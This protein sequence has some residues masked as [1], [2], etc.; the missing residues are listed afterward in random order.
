M[1]FFTARQNSRLTI[2]FAYKY[3]QNAS[4]GEIDFLLC[5]AMI[6]VKDGD[7]AARECHNV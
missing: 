4:A 5:L 3:P 6:G 1:P 2:D 7:C